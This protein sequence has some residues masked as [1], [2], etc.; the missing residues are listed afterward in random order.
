M[1]VPDCT[2]HRVDGPHESH[3][4]LL[5]KPAIARRALLVDVSREKFR[6][7]PTEIQDLVKLVTVKQTVERLLARRVEEASQKLTEARQALEEC[8]TERSELQVE[9]AEKINR[10]AKESL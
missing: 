1:S 4:A 8:V 2:C 6:D 10:Y 7:L 9:L 3:C 5:T